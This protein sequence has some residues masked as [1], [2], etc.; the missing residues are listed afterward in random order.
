[1]TMEGATPRPA[2]SPRPGATNP[3]TVWSR[4]AWRQLTSMRVALMLLLLLAVVA[5]PGSLFPQRPQDPG[6]VL[7]YI[8][9]NPTVGPILDRLGF[10][11]VFGSAWF[12]AVYILLFVSLVGCILPRIGAHWKALRTPPPRVPS[13]LTRFPEHRELR[14]SLTPTEAEEAVAKR[15][16]GYRVER[17]EAGISAER[18]YLRESGNIVFHVALVGILLSF[19]Y[20]QLATYRGQA[21]VV[22]GESFANSVLD[23]DSFSAGA[24]VEEAALDPFR[25]TLEDMTAEFRPS[26]NAD[27]FGADV[28]VTDSSGASY[29]TQ[30]LPNKPLRSGGT[31]VY[32]S[33]NGYAP[34]IE[35][36]DAAG[37]LAFSGAVPFLAQDDAYTSTGVVKVP[38]VSTG[39]QLGF[40]GQLLPT[41][42][43]D[44]DD[45][46]SAHPSP[47]NPV[48][49]LWVWQGDLGLDN[50]IPQNV[51]RLETEGMTE[52]LGD[53]GEPVIL[54]LSPGQTVD[55]PDG[56]GTITFGELPRYAALDLRHDPSL[57]W[58]LWSSVA[59]MLGL[60]ASLFTPRRRV[61]VRTREEDGVTVV[62]A[63]ALA[64]GEDAGLAS[65]LDS[66][67]KEVKAA[68]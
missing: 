66:I 23:Y 26:G 8:D 53:D 61:W 55:L 67:L 50:G 65:E 56:L 35:V 17:S 16:R 33:G 46:Y 24:F 28:T 44:G 29:P 63:A 59:A 39:P 51:Y 12:A 52:V 14:T 68:S 45:L 40:T 32:L 6:A 48:L 42:V 15:L 36:R 64:R 4:W 62:E 30:I 10:F 20:G 54:A 43:Q 3:V 60:T 25:F 38:D 9:A 2:L 37:E 7:E 34:L 27:Y 47:S 13:R 1:M 18:G 49:L 22:E 19:A 41:A 11:N 31:A 58:L 5:V 21:I 57:G